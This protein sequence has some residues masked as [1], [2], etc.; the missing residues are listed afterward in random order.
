[1][2]RDRQTAENIPLIHLHNVAMAIVRGRKRK[3][4]MDLETV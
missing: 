2:P 1:M 4:C 3:N